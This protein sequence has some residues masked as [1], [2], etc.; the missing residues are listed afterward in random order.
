MIHIH[1]WKLLD[2]KNKYCKVKNYGILKGY[3]VLTFYQCSK[4]GK[5][6]KKI[7]WRKGD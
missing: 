7:R 6:K 3:D 1:K 2:E 5:V 4:C